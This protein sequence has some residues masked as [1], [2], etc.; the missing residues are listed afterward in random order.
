MD[1]LVLFLYLK[2]QLN[3]LFTMKNVLLIYTTTTLYLLNSL[4]SKTAQVSWH[5]KSKLFWI[6]MKQEMMG[7]SGISW[8]ICKSFAPCSTPAHH[9]SVAP[10]PTERKSTEGTPCIYSP[11]LKPYHNIILTVQCSIVEIL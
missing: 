5:Q 10:Q 7:G 9:H 1:I 8:T 2:S 11:L 6:L 3:Y 4:F